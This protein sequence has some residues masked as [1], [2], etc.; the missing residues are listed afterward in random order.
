MYVEKESVGWSTGLSNEEQEARSSKFR[1]WER[2]KSDGCLVCVNKK[3]QIFVELK[4]LKS[5]VQEAGGCWP[6]P[7]SRLSP[8]R[9]LNT[10]TAPPLVAY[11]HCPPRTSMVPPS[12]IFG[13]MK[14]H[15]CQSKHF[16]SQL[17]Y[18]NF[19]HLP[20]SSTSHATLTLKKKLVSMEVM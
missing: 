19:P 17:H 9:H 11:L 13:E 8:T 18:I 6:A 1:G 16:I 4:I 20:P 7:R 3:M 14:F 15:I 2:I 5:L 12:Y 10:H